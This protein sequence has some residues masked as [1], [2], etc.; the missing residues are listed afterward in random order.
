MK[1][2]QNDVKHILYGV[3]KGADCKNHDYFHLGPMGQRQRQHFLKQ[4][5]I[6]VILI[7]FWPVVYGVFNVADLKYNIGFLLGWHRKLMQRQIKDF[8]FLWLTPV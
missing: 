3:F 5:E 4:H 6:W 7:H 8:E 2:D 1:F